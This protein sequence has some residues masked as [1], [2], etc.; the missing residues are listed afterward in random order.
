M[1][2]PKEKLSTDA[3]RQS[4]MIL[5]S[6]KLANSPAPKERGCSF[7]LCLKLLSWDNVKLSLLGNYCGGTDSSDGGQHEDGGDVTGLSGGSGS[8]RSSS[9]GFG[10]R[11]SFGSSGSFFNGSRFLLYYGR[12]GASFMVKS[13]VDSSAPSPVH[14]QPAERVHNPAQDRWNKQR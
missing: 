5:P 10:S 11:R 13:G 1:F 4:A 6:A 7:Q 12:G 2:L 9:D 8:G 14:V 3:L